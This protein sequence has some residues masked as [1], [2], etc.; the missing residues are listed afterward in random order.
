MELGVLSLELLDLPGQVDC[1]WLQQVQAFQRVN[2]ETA[3]LVWVRCKFGKRAVSFVDFGTMPHVM[4]K[5]AGIAND[6]RI[7]GFVC[8]PRIAQYRSAI[9]KQ[10]NDICNIGHILEITRR[11]TGIMNAKLAQGIC[12]EK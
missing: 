11:L 1:L 5:C 10:R 3:Q 9:I 7:Y 6:E 12:Y 8:H 2:Y 4:H